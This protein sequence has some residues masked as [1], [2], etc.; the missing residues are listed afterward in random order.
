MFSDS[1]TCSVWVL[2]VLMQPVKRSI[3]VKENQ[4]QEGEGKSKKSKKQLKKKSEAEQ[5][6]ENR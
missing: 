3:E 4:T 6:L 1:L 5:K 2:L